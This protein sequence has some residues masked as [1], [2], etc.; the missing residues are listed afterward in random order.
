MAFNGL[1]DERFAPSSGPSI[2]R[3]ERVAEQRLQD[4]RRAMQGQ[5][6]GWAARLQPK[7]S[8]CGLRQIDRH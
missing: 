1:W 3:D 7:A 2:L 4:C 5:R 6:V 8:A